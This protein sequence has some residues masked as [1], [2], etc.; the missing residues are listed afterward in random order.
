[1]RFR[2]ADNSTAKEVKNF[3]DT[4]RSPE[5][6]RNPAIDLDKAEIVNID[7]LIKAILKDWYFAFAALSNF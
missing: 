4:F 1:L 5:C 6:L 2:I 7:V 3:C